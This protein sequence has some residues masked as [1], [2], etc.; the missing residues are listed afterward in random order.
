VRLFSRVRSNVTSLVLET[1]KGLVAERTLVGPWEI[2]AL[3]ILALLRGVL[4]QRSH[5]A[6]SRSSH[7]G[8]CS[9]S[10]RLLRV[11]SGCGGVGVQEVLKTC[12]EGVGLHVTGSRKLGEGDDGGLGYMYGSTRRAC[13]GR[14]TAV[15]E[16]LC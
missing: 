16:R 5:E 11:S 4:Q 1:V 13:G 12:R 2:L 8:V 9:S 7:G 6:H 3:V 14:L 10:G 15:L